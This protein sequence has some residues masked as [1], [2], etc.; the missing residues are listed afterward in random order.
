LNSCLSTIVPFRKKEVVLQ[1]HTQLLTGMEEEI[2]ALKKMLEAQRI[3]IDALKSRLAAYESVEAAVQSANSIAVLPR[4]PPEP[5]LSKE[6]VA[7]FSRQMILPEFRPNGQLALKVLNGHLLT[8]C[9]TNPIVTDSCPF[10][11]Y[12]KRFCVPDP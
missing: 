10:F 7:K 8:V 5:K 2:R 4:L 6:D 3:E 1:I 9:Y 11:L 12:K